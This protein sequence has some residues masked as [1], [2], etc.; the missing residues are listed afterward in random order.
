[1][2]RDEVDLVGICDVDDSALKG[3]KEIIS[4]SGK[5]VPE[6]FTGDNYAWKKM[7]EINGGLDGVLI[8]TPWEWHKPMIM[9]AL[10]AGIKYIATE[11]ILGITLQDHWDVV[12][13]TETANANVMMLDNVCYRRDVMAVLNMVM[14]GLFGGLIHLQGG[15]Q[16]D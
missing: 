7:L 9:G 13:A 16:P 12:N 5:K 3:A 2:R 6:I 10:A 14:P 8:V 1:M 15:Y 11:V 4:K